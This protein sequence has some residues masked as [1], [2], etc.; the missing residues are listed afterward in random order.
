MGSKSRPRRN[1]RK[2]LLIPHFLLT[3]WK[4]F[5]GHLTDGKKSLDTITGDSILKAG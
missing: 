4:R 1:R 2:Y 3:S 5:F